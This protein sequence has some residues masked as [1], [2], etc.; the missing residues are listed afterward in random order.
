[1]YHWPG[2]IRELRH[3]LERAILLTDRRIEPEH[4][5]LPGATA[6]V[7]PPPADGRSQSFPENVTLPELE[8]LFIQRIMQKAQ[9]NVSRAARLLGISR[10]ALRRRLEASGT[11]FDD[12]SRTGGEG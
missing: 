8:S 6:A 11:A 4:L 12:D 9:G 10:G 1:R 7:T 3:V 5:G 2:N